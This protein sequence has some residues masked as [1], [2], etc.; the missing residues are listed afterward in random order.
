MSWRRILSRSDIAWHRSLYGRVVVGFIVLVAVELAAQGTVFVWLVERSDRATAAPLT[1]GFADRLSRALTLN[2]GLDVSGWVSQLETP[3]YVFVILRD[4]RTAG[5]RTPS[6]ATVRLV[7]D[8]LGHPLDFPTMASSWANSTYRGVPVMLNGEIVGAL[9][10]VP[11]T[12]FQ[13]VGPEAVA[14]G[15]GLLIL[16]TLVSSIFIVGPVRRRIQDLQHAARRLGEGDAAARATEGGGDEVADLASTF[17]SMADELEER[18]AA[19]EASDGARRHLI[20]DVSHELMTPLTAILGHLETQTMAEVRLDDEKRQRSVAISIR[21]AK[22]LERLIGELLD[23][24]RL[25]AGGGDLQMQEVAV[26]DL[27]EQVIANHEHDARARDISIVSSVTKEAKS[28]FGDPFRLEQVL[29][30]VTSNAIRHAHEGGVIEMK[31]EAVNDA[32]VLTVS[33]AGD[34]IAPDQLPF[35]FDRFFK[36]AS[37]KGVASRGSG[38]G[39]SIVKA[40]VV[41][42]G[43]HVS[44]TSAPDRGTTIRIELPAVHRSDGMTQLADPGARMRTGVLW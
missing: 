7:I 32:V 3:E 44:A 13:R 35:I 27:F 41:R 43:G 18:A 22:R 28:L 11:R 1:Q 14:I 34:G 36:A 38:L 6:E 42:H 10:M 24:A 17:N 9:G 23:A 29:E 15:L 16:G 25:E 20:A 33:D 5:A 2:Q 4:G 8:Q 12:T 26:A 21:E 39:L 30:N 19:L 40:I 31:A 37:A